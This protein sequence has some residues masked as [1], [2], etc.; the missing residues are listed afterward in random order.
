M[1]LKDID[2]VLELAGQLQLERE[3]AAKARAYP[4]DVVPVESAASIAFRLIRVELPPVPKSV[5]VSA[6][7]RAVSK[8]I[9]ELQQLGV[10]VDD[11]PPAQS[12]P[13]QG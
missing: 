4:H 10:V 13:T 7:E 2:K 9:A 3:I 5:F 11:E 1:N 12:Q 6:A 8:T